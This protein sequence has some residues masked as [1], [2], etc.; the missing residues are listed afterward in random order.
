MTLLFH[1]WWMSYSDLISRL[2][3]SHVLL[4]HYVKSTAKQWTE[5]LN[6]N[7][8]LKKDMFSS[9]WICSI[10]KYNTFSQYYRW[11][12]GVYILFIHSTNKKGFF[13]LNCKLFMLTQ[14]Y[15]KWYF[16]RNVWSWR[17]F[18]INNLLYEV[19]ILKLDEVFF[20]FLRGRNFWKIHF[21]ENFHT[22]A[23]RMVQ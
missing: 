1:G 5:R 23:L 20:F 8:W 13:L 4:S 12:C 10:R 2:F 11:K 9:S 3:F 18:A 14:R 7:W 15:Y 6:L 16:N 19:H 22:C 17:F 21:R